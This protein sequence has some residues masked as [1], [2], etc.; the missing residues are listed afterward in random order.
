MVLWK[1][2]TEEQKE[3]KRN[4]LRKWRKANPEKTRAQNTRACR[5]YRQTHPE[6]KYSN[7][8]REVKELREFK[9]KILE[10]AS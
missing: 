8:L 9:R 6:R 3:Y 5:R 2:M 7:I 1:N 4:E 10:M